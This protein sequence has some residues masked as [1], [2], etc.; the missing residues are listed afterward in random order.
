[1]YPDFIAVKG[2]VQPTEG[3]CVLSV[4]EL[5]REEF[6]VGSR[7]FISAETQLIDYMYQAMATPLCLRPLHGFLVMRQWTQEYCLVETPAG[8]TFWYKVGGLFSTTSDEFL[9]RLHVQAVRG[10]N[11]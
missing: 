3:D 1:M 7:S 5:K 11:L 2:T 8:D 4:I 6:S 10:W 9:D